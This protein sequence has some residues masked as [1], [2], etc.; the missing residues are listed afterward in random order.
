M[1]VHCVNTCMGT[2]PGSPSALSNSA[3]TAS[4]R[5]S[6]LTLLFKEFPKGGP[7][8]SIFWSNV[9]N[10]HIMPAKK[11]AVTESQKQK[12]QSNALRPKE[13]KLFL[14][15]RNKSQMQWLSISTEN[16]DMSLICNS[17]ADGEVSWVVF[18]AS[19]ENGAW[20]FPQLGLLMG[21]P[22][23]SSL[24]PTSCKL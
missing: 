10:M 23:L 22:C 1:I 3:S 17:W 21:S 24:S 2:V 13:A 14:P 6:F 7:G 15:G 9:S 16:A 8:P 18:T 11:W 4:M 12:N 19:L 20:L 5:R